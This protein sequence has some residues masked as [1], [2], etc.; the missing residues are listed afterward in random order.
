MAT[1]P[2]ETFDAEAVERTIRDFQQRLQFTGWSD[3]SPEGTF[4]RSADALVEWS[5]VAPELK[6]NDTE[7]VENSIRFKWI[8]VRQELGKRLDAEAVLRNW[9]ESTGGEGEKQEALNQEYKSDGLAR[10][11]L[12]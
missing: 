2:I 1:A 4:T 12:R 8:G 10:S 6:S 7:I 3:V 5:P 9:R 11:P